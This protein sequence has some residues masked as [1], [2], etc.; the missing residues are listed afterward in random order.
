M[1]AALLGGKGPQRL[2]SHMLRAIRMFPDNVRTV[3][4]AQMEDAMV[5]SMST[6]SR[7]L[8]KMDVTLMLE[9]R[10]MHKEAAARKDV[11]Y[12]LADSSPIRQRNYL[13]VEHFALRG[14]DVTA[15]GQAAL[16]MKDLADEVR[17]TGIVRQEAFDEAILAAEQIRSTSRQGSRVCKG[18]G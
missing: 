11:L 1:L 13:W 15:S 7:G 9:R 10:V 14:D 3:L 8:L 12:I 4:E 5:P 16:H 6:M 17:E 2:K 18:L